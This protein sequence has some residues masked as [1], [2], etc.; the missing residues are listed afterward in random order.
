[1]NLGLGCSSNQLL[2]LTASHRHI[3]SEQLQV[4]E[5]VG[6]AVSQVGQSE[7]HV[8]DSQPG[9]R[10]CSKRVPNFETQGTHPLLVGSFLNWFLVTGLKE[11]NTLNYHAAHVSFRFRVIWHISQGQLGLS[12]CANPQ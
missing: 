3:A 1:M 9:P 5:L 10:F 11:L 2:E 4:I 6:F 12:S 8:D 7:D